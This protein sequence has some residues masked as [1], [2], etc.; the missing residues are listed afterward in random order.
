MGNLIGLSL[1]RSLETRR[2]LRPTV[3]T[4]SA[5]LNAMQ[6]AALWARLP[7]SPSSGL[8]GPMPS[9]P[10]GAVG[11]RGV[12]RSIYLRRYQLGFVSLGTP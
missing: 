7:S 4:E 6:R 9:L 3:V 8:A 1:S 12:E 11:F 5:R 10:E 2:R